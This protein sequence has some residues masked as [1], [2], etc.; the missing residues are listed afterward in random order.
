MS[1]FITD[2]ISLNGFNIYGVILTTTLSKNSSTKSKT[3][4][5]L[6][7]IRRNRTYISAYVV[8]TD[9]GML[10]NTGNVAQVK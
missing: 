8:R 3:P 2:F 4:F 1:I 5:L 9:T 7:S 10:F 6:V